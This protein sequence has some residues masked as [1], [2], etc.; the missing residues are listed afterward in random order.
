VVAFNWSRPGVSLA[1]KD[2]ETWI[3]ETW[4]DLRTAGHGGVSLNGDGDQF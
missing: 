4:T 1:P 3:R 2:V